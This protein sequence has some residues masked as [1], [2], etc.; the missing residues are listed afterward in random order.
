M[1]GDFTVSVLRM[2]GD[3]TVSVLRMVGDFTVSVLRMVGDF[4]VSV[5]SLATSPYLCF[6]EA[7]A[8][9]SGV[10][11]ATPLGLLFTELAILTPTDHQ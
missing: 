3:F 6:A 10:V 4:T 7:F 9:L 2:V 1:V 8:Y 11:S 5:L